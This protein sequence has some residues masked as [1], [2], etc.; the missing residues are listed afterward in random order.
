MKIIIVSGYI[1]ESKRKLEDI[2]AEQYVK[3]NVVEYKISNAEGVLKTNEDEYYTAR[4]DNLRGQ[5]ADEVLVYSRIT[6]GD[7][8]EKVLPVVKYDTKKLSLWS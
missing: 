5:R 1:G 8:F 2:Y 7:V 6:I 4:L 3:S